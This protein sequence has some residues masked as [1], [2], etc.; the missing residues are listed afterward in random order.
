[1]NGVIE[2]PLDERWMNDERSTLPRP[3]LEHAVHRRVRAGEKQLIEMRNVAAALREEEVESRRF[4]CRFP[5]E[6]EEG[7]EARARRRPGG[8]GRRRRFRRPGRRW[9]A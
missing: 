4:Q 7:T 2:R 5:R 1:M 6:E 8:G 3:R 9:V